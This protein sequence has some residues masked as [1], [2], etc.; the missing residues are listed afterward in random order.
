MGL[1]PRTVTRDTQRPS[2]PT[3]TQTGRTG[4]TDRTLRWQATLA[5]SSLS[6]ATDASA[7]RTAAVVVVVAA[8]D[9]VAHFGSGG[10]HL[11]GGLVGAGLDRAIAVSPAIRPQVSKRR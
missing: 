6:L 8:A 5:L 4:H 10:A 11:G 3:R 7:A 9:T 1:A 2:L